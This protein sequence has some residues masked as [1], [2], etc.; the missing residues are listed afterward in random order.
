MVLALPAAIVL[1]AGAVGFLLVRPHGAASA[2][3]AATSVSYAFPAGEYSDGLTIVR[4]WT[5]SGHDG[6]ELTETVTASNAASA[7]AQHSFEEVI[8]TTIATGLTTVKFSP[9]LAKVVR[10]DPVVEWQLQLP[11]GHR[12]VTVGYRA[13]VPAKGLDVAR[14]RQWAKDLTTQATQLHV[15]MPASITISTLSVSPGKVSLKTGA[16]TQLKLNGKLASGG[17]V[18]AQILSG[19]SWTTSNEKVATISSTGKVTAVG[20]GKATVTAQIGTTHATATV[21]VAQS[22]A[23]VVAGSGVAGSAPRQP[24]QPS[25]AFQPSASPVSGFFGGGSNG[26][27]NGGGGSTKKPPSDVTTTKATTGTGSTYTEVVDENPTPSWSDYTT[28]AGAQG[29]TLAGQEGVQVSC[30]VSGRQLAEGNDTWYRIASSPWNNAYYAFAGAFWN[31]AA[32]GATSKPAYDP[33]V[34]PC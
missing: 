15:P 17:A 4:R 11:A 16:A 22:S 3:S 20:A 31:G 26:G 19:A 13:T 1:L 5:L 12:T 21:T 7:A 28:G 9:A 8:P 23:N 32:S 2:A 10:A 6:S 25:T 24:Q 34:P 29:T 30:R 18:S 27:G 14:L 33:A